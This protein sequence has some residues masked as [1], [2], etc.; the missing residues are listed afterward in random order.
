M[1]EPLG[2]K[3]GNFLEVEESLDCL[4]GRG[5]A[6]LMELTYRLGAWML[7]AGGKARDPAEA[8][9][10]CEA[11]VSSG[12][13]MRLF[14]DNVRGQGGDPD[15]MLAMRGKARSAHSFELKAG[16]EGFLAI[17][18]YGIGL[19]GVYLGVGRDK[20]TDP[21]F[22]DVGFEFIRKS[23]E[24]VRPGAPICVVYGKDGKALEAARPLIEGAVAVSAAPPARRPLIMKEIAAE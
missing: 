17:D 6:D 9:R 23:G 13:A 21:V 8:R 5:P 16:A 7:V 15:R 14:M 4:E 11:A 3:V 18:A 10:V 24:R 20:T 19:A 22:P 2:L 12:D 1:T